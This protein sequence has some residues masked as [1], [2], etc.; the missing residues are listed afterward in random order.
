MELKNLE[1]RRLRLILASDP[2]FTVLFRYLLNVFL[3]LFSNYGTSPALALVFSLK[4]ILAFAIVYVFVP[5]A[6]PTSSRDRLFSRLR[7]ILMLFRRREG[8]IASFRS[9]TST[10]DHLQDYQAFLADL[11]AA[12]NQIPTIFRTL[13]PRIYSVALAVG[14]FSKWAHGF[15]NVLKSP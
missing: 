4:V 7:Q 8:L 2:D 1:T 10:V 9:N 3:E 14:R 6:S 5:N 11:N 12:P 15:L 13:A